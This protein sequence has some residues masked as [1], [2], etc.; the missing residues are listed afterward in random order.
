L[1]GLPAILTAFA[2]QHGWAIVRE[3]YPFKY[4]LF[5]VNGARQSYRLT[6]APQARSGV[7]L[8]KASRINCRRSLLFSR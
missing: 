3:F 7:T 2:R 4:D 8:A 5:P 6:Q 1:A